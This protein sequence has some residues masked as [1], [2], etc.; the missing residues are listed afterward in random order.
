[1]REPLVENQPKSASVGFK[2]NKKVISISKIAN[3]FRSCFGLGVEK[4]IS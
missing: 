2:F 4:K 1:M 3:K